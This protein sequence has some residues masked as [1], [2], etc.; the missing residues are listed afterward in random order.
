M[1]KKKDVGIVGLTT[2]EASKM[3]PGIEERQ[4]AR[5][6]LKGQRLTRVYGSDPPAKELKT[7]LF[8]KRVGKYWI[9]PITELQRV[10]MP[11]DSDSLN[12]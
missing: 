12:V 1:K 9:I 6:C 8:G 5:M 11:D 10:F 3:L 7:A 4:F 2:F